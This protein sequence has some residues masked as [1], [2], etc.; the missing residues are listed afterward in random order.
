[1][2]R[3]LL[4]P[5]LMS[6]QQMTVVDVGQLPFYAHLFQCLIKG[7]HICQRLLFLYRLRQHGQ[8]TVDID[9]QIRICIPDFLQPFFVAP[10][11]KP[12]VS[13]AVFQIV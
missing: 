6:G 3:I 2:H 10:N 5:V 13:P 1:M 4:I 11:K 8:N 9:G 7:I 12:A